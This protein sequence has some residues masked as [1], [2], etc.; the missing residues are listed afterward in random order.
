MSDRLLIAGP[1]SLESDEVSLRVANRMRALTFKYNLT[2]VFKGS[3]DKANRTSG[4]SPRGVG[5]EEGLRILERVRRDVGCPTITDVH[6]TWQIT[7]VAS[8][9]DVLQIPAMLSRQTDLIVES[10]KASSAGLVIKKGQAM[11]VDGLDD[12]MRKADKAGSFATIACLRGTAFGNGDLVMDFRDVVDLKA[13]GRQ[14][15]VDVTHGVMTKHRGLGLYGLGINMTRINDYSMALTRAAT[16]VG[17]DGVFAEVHPDPSEAPSDQN[18]M[19]PLSR[20]E[21]LVKAVAG[22]G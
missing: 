1:C 13:L 15:I 10:A 16:A 8:V 18:W 6:E 4:D 3:F 20:A 14:V 5:M 2:Y 7:P 12:A 22:E 11:D 21:E 17:A 9:V 19:L